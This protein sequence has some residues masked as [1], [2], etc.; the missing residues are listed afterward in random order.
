M[1][2]LIKVKETYSRCSKSR[3]GRVSSAVENEASEAE[4]RIVRH[5]LAAQLV[6]E[7]HE[8]D[9]AGTRVDVKALIPR[10]TTKPFLGH[11]NVCAR[12]FDRDERQT[13]RLPLTFAF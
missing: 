8:R 7:K 5:R 1:R 2:Q 6:G 10:E 9:D 4:A 12:A 3:V 13:I 11:E